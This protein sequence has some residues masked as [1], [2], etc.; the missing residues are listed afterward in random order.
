MTYIDLS[1][2]SFFIPL[3][4][5]LIVFLISYAVIKKAGLFDNNFWQL[6]V[7]FLISIIFV[8][9][10]GP[11]FYVATIIPWFAIF[12]VAFV[13]VLAVIGFVKTGKG[14]SALN[15]SK[16]MTM[17]F[18]IGLLLIFVISGIFVFS[19][20]ISPYLPWSSGYGGNS[21]VL[22]VTDWLYQPRVYGALLLLAVAG[23]VS[24]FL[25]R[26]VKK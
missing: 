17:V 8:S 14:E 2:F 15:W 19:S 9:T 12:I 7:S 26:N 21:D 10:S 13:L 1:G 22:S 3:L 18:A 4:T 16:G 20:Y 5:F 11:A 6:F 23:L 24:W 25:A